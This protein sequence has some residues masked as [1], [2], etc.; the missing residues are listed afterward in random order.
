MIRFDGASGM[1]M[2]GGFLERH[3]ALAAITAT[4]AALAEVV[5]AGVLG[6]E[7]ANPG[8]FLLTDTTHKGH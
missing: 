1:R 5:I 6:A 7:G 4:A 3:F 2:R 8:G